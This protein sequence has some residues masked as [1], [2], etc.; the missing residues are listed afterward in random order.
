MLGPWKHLSAVKRGCY[1][2]LGSESLAAGELLWAHRMPL[3]LALGVIVMAEP[4]PFSVP[5]S[6][7]VVA[8]P[9]RVQASLCPAAASGRS[10]PRS[11]Q[12]RSPGAAVTRVTSPWRLVGLTLDEEG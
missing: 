5:A 2:P 8:R 1:Q 4:A 12:R 9:R 11:L 10:L 3:A 7:K 6:W